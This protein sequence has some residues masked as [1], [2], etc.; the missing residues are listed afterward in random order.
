MDDI[1]GRYL[2]YY[3]FINIV[4]KI[5]TVLFV[6]VCLVEVLDEIL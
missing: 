4:M 5:E 6:Y 2:I 3:Q 1:E